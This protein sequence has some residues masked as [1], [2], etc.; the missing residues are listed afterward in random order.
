MI[1]NR[2]T[3]AVTCETRSAISG[4][5]LKQITAQIADPSA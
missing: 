3:I 2:V 5:T 1:K 4:R